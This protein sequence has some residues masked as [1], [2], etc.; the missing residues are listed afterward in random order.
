MDYDSGYLIDYLDRSRTAGTASRLVTF[1]RADLLALGSLLAFLG[2]LAAATPGPDNVARNLATSTSVILA[3]ALGAIASFWAAR[4]WSKPIGLGEEQVIV[5][6][7]ELVPTPFP[8]SRISQ[9]D[10]FDDESKAA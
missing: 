2:F 7:L 5:R 10:T 1:S 4:K 6:R 9:T 3:L 8:I